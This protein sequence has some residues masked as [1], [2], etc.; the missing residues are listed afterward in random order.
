M[1][2]RFLVLFIAVTLAG[3]VAQAQ[4]SQADKLFKS[5]SYSSAIPLYLKIA[6]KPGDPDRNY[7]IIKLADCYRLSNDQLNAKAWYSRAVNLPNSENINWFYYGE[8]LQCA[9]E[10][11]LAKEAF[12]KYDYLNPDDP[13]GK[14]YA[15]FCAEAQKLSDIPPGF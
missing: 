14:A 6:Q 15:S 9:Q 1:N 2:K 8:A 3:T 10:Y 5:Y 7:A 12:E 13:R 11:D 4:I